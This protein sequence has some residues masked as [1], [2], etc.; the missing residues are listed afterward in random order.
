MLPFAHLGIGSLLG[1]PFLKRLSPKWLLV[2]TLLPD[3]ID[4]PVFFMMGVYAYLDH[5]GWVPGKRGLGHTLLFLA[6]LALAGW[7]KRSRIL[8]A[9]TVGVCT[10]LVLDLFSKISGPN[11][12][13]EPLS[14]FLWPL[15]GIDFPTLSY[16]MHGRV[17]MA[18]EVLGGVLL[19]FFLRKYG[20]EIFK[21]KAL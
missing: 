7:L 1:R 9:V 19:L 14:V 10:H 15:L 21:R 5:G 8:I 17:A 6:I 20:S 3:L 2:G 12:L 13:R 16:G 11:G 4:K 18:F